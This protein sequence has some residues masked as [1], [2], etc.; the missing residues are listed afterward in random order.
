MLTM[1]HPLSIRPQKCARA[2]ALQHQNPSHPWLPARLAHARRGSKEYVFPPMPNA[3][4]NTKVP[5]AGRRW[6]FACRIFASDAN[7]YAA[8]FGRAT[9]VMTRGLRPPFSICRAITAREICVRSFW[10]ASRSLPYQD[11]RVASRTPCCHRQRCARRR[12]HA[13]PTR[14]ETVVRCLRA[15]RARALRPT[16]FPLTPS[17]EFVCENDAKR[18]PIGEIRGESLKPQP[19]TSRAHRPSCRHPC[20]R[21]LCTLRRDPCRPKVPRR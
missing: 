8:I 2:R 11:T 21:P 5:T 6:I 19:N 13:E 15:K 20:A 3:G 14:S 18:G 10:R 4:G 9:R 1:V 16:A 12:C 7:A 17:D